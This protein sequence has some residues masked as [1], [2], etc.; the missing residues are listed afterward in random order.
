MGHTTECLCSPDMGVWRDSSGFAGVK[1]VV[2]GEF[3]R[4]RVLAAGLKVG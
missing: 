3:G 4:D 2:E 1:M